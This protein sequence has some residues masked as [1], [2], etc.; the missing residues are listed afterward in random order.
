ME[1]ARVV[2]AAILNSQLKDLK[3]DLDTPD[4]QLFLDIRGALAFIY[5]EIHRGIDGIPSLSQGKAV[6]IIKPNYNSLLAAW[7]MKKRGVKIIPIFF[8]TGK[9]DEKE[10]LKFVKTEFDEDITIINLKNRLHDFKD[11][12][13]LCML[14]QL[15][16]EK[17]SETT[18]KDLDISTLISP[19][20]F[21]FHNEKMSLEA[22]KILEKDISTSVLRPLQLGF[23]GD[24]LSNEDFDL[25]P[26]CT[27]RSQISIQLT[28][29]FNERSVKEFLNIEAR[30]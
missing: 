23:Y 30:D 11:N 18:S 9:P 10:Y 13:S 25:D 26:C 21:N 3:V 27:Y 14:C 29:D 2:G 8:K 7:L 24:L 5:T 28:I 16:C 4:F 1:I 15:Y 22:L 12:S 20:C 19:T 6:A 17:H